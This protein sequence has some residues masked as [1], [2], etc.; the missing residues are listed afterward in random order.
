MINETLHHDERSVFRAV[1][2]QTSTFPQADGSIARD[3][4]PTKGT[5]PMAR[6]FA[7]KI[8]S[9]GR[10]VR[11]TDTKFETGGIKI[12]DYLYDGDAAVRKI[13]RII[14]ETLLEVEFDFPSDIANGDVLICERQTFKMIIAESTGTAD[15]V[16]QEAPF[17]VGGRVVHGGAP[18]AY[19]ASASDAEISFSV[20]Q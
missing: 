18:L 12:G 17:R 4:F 11:G 10:M 3:T 8:D 5:V 20:S 9:D 19:D 6:T 13:T 15:A 14:S 7:G 16:L 1:T 2:G